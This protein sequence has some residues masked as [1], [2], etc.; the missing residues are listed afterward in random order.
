MKN[1]EIWINKQVNTFQCRLIVRITLEPILNCK[2]LF[3][4]ENKNI[5]KLCLISSSNA[6]FLWRLPLSYLD[7]IIANV[8]NG[9][10]L[11]TSS[12]ILLMSVMYKGGG[13]YLRFYSIKFDVIKLDVKLII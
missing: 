1:Q 3:K 7:L 6:V 10:F 8:L 2:T 9:H 5:E 4:K 12:I 13:Q 11:L